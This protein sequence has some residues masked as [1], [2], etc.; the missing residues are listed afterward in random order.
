MVIY[1]NGTF[2][3]K[4][5]EAQFTCV[6]LAWNNLAGSRHFSVQSDVLAQI[7]NS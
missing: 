2:S 4:M 6:D 1:V 7:I 3:C 5:M